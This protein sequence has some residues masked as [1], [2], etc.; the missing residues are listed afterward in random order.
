MNKPNPIHKPGPI[1]TFAHSQAANHEI[2]E[3]TDV[4]VRRV[5][6]ALVPSE[7]YNIVLT[8]VRHSVDLSTEATSLM[9]G[10]FAVDQII[11]KL[12]REP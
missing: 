4:A 5:T 9:P 1:F 11:D 6:Q 10:S 7:L 8:A 12:W 3:E 2:S